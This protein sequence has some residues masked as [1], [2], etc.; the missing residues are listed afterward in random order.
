MNRSGS[1]IGCQAVVKFGD[2][3]PVGIEWTQAIRARIRLTSLRFDGVRV[4]PYAYGGSVARDR[5]MIE[6]PDPLMPDLMIPFYDLAEV[7][8]LEKSCYFLP[9]GPATIN[10]NDSFLR[11]VARG[12]RTYLAAREGL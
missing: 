2:D 7:R 6:I 5:Y 12:Q 3:L 9:I 4:V 8:S 11:A 1:L 10:G